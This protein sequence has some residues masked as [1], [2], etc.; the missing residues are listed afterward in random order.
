MGLGVAIL[1]DSVMRS[2]NEPVMRSLHESVVRVATLA[3]L[4]RASGG[5]RHAVSQHLGLLLQLLELLLAL[6]LQVFLVFATVL[7]SEVRD[8]P[9]EHVKL[10]TGLFLFKVL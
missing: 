6:G 8:V 2:L 3:R 7:D 5:R 1:D 4:R 10:F 9:E